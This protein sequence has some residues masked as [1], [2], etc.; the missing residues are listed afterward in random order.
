[1]KFKESM[2]VISELVDQI[3]KEGNNQD[4]M[5]ILSIVIYFYCDFRYILSLFLLKQDFQKK[6]LQTK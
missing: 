5:S 1:M 3:L 6:K 4:S 2:K